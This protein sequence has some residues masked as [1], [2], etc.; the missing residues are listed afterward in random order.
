MQRMILQLDQKCRFVCINVYNCLML[1]SL[2]DCS[3]QKASAACCKLKMVDKGRWHRC[4]KG[5]MG[6]CHWEVGRRC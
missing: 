5:I 6:I 3:T 2:L 1:F 4:Y